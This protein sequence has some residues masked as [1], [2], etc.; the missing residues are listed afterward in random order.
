MCSFSKSSLKRHGKLGSQKLIFKGSR[1]TDDK[2]H[3]EA[4]GQATHSLASLAPKTSPK[5]GERKH[6]QTQKIK[7]GPTSRKYSEIFHQGGE[8]GV[9]AGCQKQTRANAELSDEAKLRNKR[10]CSHVCVENSFSK[11][12]IP[13]TTSLCQVDA[14]LLFNRPNDVLSILIQPALTD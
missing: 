5:R 3:S 1:C 14:F 13:L 10:L 7:Q 6:R 11:S 4:V 9:A 12:F 8:K 2:N